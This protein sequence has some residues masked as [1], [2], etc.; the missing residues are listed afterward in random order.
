MS[1]RR[2]IENLSRH[3]GQ[4]QVDRPFEELDDGFVSI[5]DRTPEQLLLQA[6]ELADLLNYYPATGPPTGSWSPFLSAVD[7]QTA[8]SLVA[9]EGGDVPPHLAL[10][11]TFY[12]LYRRYPQAQINR[13]TGRHL[14]FFYEKVLRFERYPLKPDR[15][16]LVVE[17]KKGAVPQALG[18]SH[19]FQGKD[20]AGRPLIYTPTR[21]TVVSAAR[22]DS[23]RSVFRDRSG[24]GAIRF[25]PVANSADGMGTPPAGDYP[26]WP[27]FGHPGLPAAQIGF[28]LASEILR[29]GE[30]TRTVVVDLSVGGLAPARFSPAAVS[31]SL[32]VFLTGEKGWIGPFAPTATVS[33][34]SL[35]LQVTVPADRPPV[36]G[37][38]PAI[39]AGSISAR[40]PVI[41]VVL[42]S[43]APLGYND[44]S[45]LTL[46]TARLEV[47]VE[48]MTTL[49]LESDLGTLNSKKTFLPFG[50]RPGRGS[51]FTIRSPEAM[52]KTLMELKVK[53]RWNGAP[54]DFT[55]HYKNYPAA[56]TGSSFTASAD[57]GGAGSLTP[58]TPQ[59]LFE[60]LDGGF[61]IFDFKVSG[62]PAA[63]ENKKSADDWAE[64][65]EKRKLGGKPV[66][67][68][69]PEAPPG[70]L[71]F[72]YQHRSLDQEY[73]QQTIK[74]MMEFAKGTTTTLTQL[75]EP[76]VPAAG[77]LSLDYRAQSDELNLNGNTASDVSDT[78]V[79]FFQTGCFGHIQEH[80]FRRRQ[81]DFLADK[82]VSLLPRY[83]NDGEILLGIKDLAPGQSVS[84]LF[85]VAEGSA[86][87]D[88]QAPKV[89]WAVLCDDYFSP[90]GPAEVVGDT[91]R[92]LRSSGVVGFVIPRKATTANTILP[93][94]FLWIKGAVDGPVDAA[95]RLVAVAANAVEVRLEPKD[96]QAGAGGTTQPAGT[97]TKSTAALPL[98]KSVAQ[99]FP[100]EGGAAAETAES[101]RVRAAE[102]CR[103]RGRSVNRW[104]YERLIL[105]EFPSVHR[106][107]CI[108][109]AKDGSWLA[110]G[111]VLIIVVP[112]LRNHNTMDPLRPRVD[113]E[114]IDRIR[115]HLRRRTGMGVQLT[116]RNP[117][118]QRVR[119]DLKV[120]LLQG[121]EFTYYS[122]ELNTA[123]VR[124]LSPWAHDASRQVSFG[125]RVYKSVV[126]DFL[127]DLPYVDYVTDFKL[128]MPDLGE[129]DLPQAE[130][131]AP[132]AILVS[133]STHKV[134][135]AI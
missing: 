86:N 23:M 112:D 37:N 13:I 62:S 10:M 96:L 110:P 44:F 132:D 127:E 12:E 9:A 108:P 134:T 40:E 124:F 121:F 8:P 78:D 11:G 4:S 55:T 26:S 103:H 105:S 14:D 15:A 43:G 41:Q 57:L 79:Q 52:S 130:A 49:D 76:Y 35:K 51:S 131:T 74:N 5:D 80:G 56:P 77:H 1:D 36:T 27:P 68:A 122:S 133:D 115:E 89:K 75:N 63:A 46:N 69:Q 48:D 106:V 6:K 66:S 31:N 60:P 20:A 94:G 33:P 22:V 16:H 42:K 73:R 116:V 34:G 91:T 118:Y 45:A 111:H 24:S 3:Q 119:F 84:V 125:G 90:M 129:G 72:T 113:A 25:A 117:S 81:F 18:P 88:L 93:P 54:S 83:E 135:E 85:Q 53:V 107:K 99:P 58:S 32:S 70:A 109:H 126:L 29:M 7:E 59:N 21:E 28:A 87:P 65:W 50:P 64:R 39:H 61:R 92:S 95:A 19:R 71:V 2:A 123:L 101:M 128:F 17:L 98:V 47:L 100:T 38:D 82:S 120:R 114:T 97:I 30:G 104:D 67:Q 102:R